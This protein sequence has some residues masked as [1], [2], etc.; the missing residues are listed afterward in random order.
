MDRQRK[1]IKLQQRKKI[2]DV[3]GVRVEYTERKTLDKLSNMENHQGVL[4][5]VKLPQERTEEALKKV[6]KERTENA[7]Y[8]VLDQVTYTHLT[9]PTKRIVL[10]SVGTAGVIRKNMR[11]E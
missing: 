9:L 6:V 8:L 11:R 7:F 2:L 3:I 10:I 5:T 4:L 1:D